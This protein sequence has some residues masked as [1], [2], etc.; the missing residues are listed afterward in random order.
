MRA[1][2]FRQGWSLS[3]SAEPAEPGAQDAARE[4]IERAVKAHGGA[5]ALAR[6]RA[7]KVKFKG[8]IVL[9]GHNVPFVE[10][11]TVQLPTQYKHVIEL[12]DGTEKTTILH[13]IN[14]S[15]VYITINGKEQKLDP[16]ASPRSATVWSYSAPRACCRSWRTRAISSNSSTSSR[17]TIGRPSASA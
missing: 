12:S 4:L 3:C 8:N 2:S 13:I 17:S 15:N 6:N 16:A 7:E 1:S 10:E 9:R 14:G 5:E 11:T